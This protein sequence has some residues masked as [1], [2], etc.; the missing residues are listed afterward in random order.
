[1]KINTMTIYD[2][3]KEQI[4]RDFPKLKALPSH[5]IDGFIESYRENPKE[6]KKKMKVL[7]SIEEKHASKEYISYGVSKLTG[8]E[9]KKVPV[10]D[11]LLETT[12]GGSSVE[13][14][15]SDS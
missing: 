1:M 11:N 8:D 13:I 15:H 5:Y 2:D 3:W 4:Y 14:Q 7:E 6:F 9:V 10:S 12:Q